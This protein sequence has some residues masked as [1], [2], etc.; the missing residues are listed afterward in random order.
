MLK[1]IK[2]ILTKNANL[3]METNDTKFEE[4]LLIKKFN[5]VILDKRPNELIIGSETDNKIQMRVL[6]HEKQLLPNM[7][8]PSLC[9]KR[10]CSIDLDKISIRDKVVIEFDNELKKDI[11]IP[12]NSNNKILTIIDLDIKERGL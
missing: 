10:Y 3:I 2:Q 1:K 5:G 9:D 6:I 12:I 11:L 4:K 8:Y 7:I